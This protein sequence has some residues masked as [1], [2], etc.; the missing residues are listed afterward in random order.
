MATAAGTPMAYSNGVAT[1]EPPLPKTP[2]RNPMPRPTRWAAE[3]VARLLGRL[4]REHPNVAVRV[5]EPEADSTL[6]DT[7]TSGRAELG[8][9]DLSRGVGGGLVAT[10]LFEQELLL[11]APPGTD[12]P[13]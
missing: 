8:I 2:P 6:L 7:V 4:R 10:K 13:A 11:V 12:L 9:A 3:P 1:A 5:I